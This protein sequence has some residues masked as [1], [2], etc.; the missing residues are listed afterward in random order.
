MYLWLSGRRGNVMF[1]EIHTRFLLLADGRLQQQS[2]AIARRVK[3]VQRGWHRDHG[4]DPRVAGT[5][6]SNLIGVPAITPVDGGVHGLVVV[7]QVLLN[8]GLRRLSTADTPQQP[9]I[10]VALVHP[11]GLPAWYECWIRIAGLLVPSVPRVR[12]RLTICKSIAAIQRQWTVRFGARF[13]TYGTVDDYVCVDSRHTPETAKTPEIAKPAE[14]PKP[15]KRLVLIRAYGA[16]SRIVRQ[17]DVGAHH[18]AL[19]IIAHTWD[20]WAMNPQ[21]AEARAFGVERLWNVVS[22]VAATITRLLAVVAKEAQPPNGLLRSEEHLL[23]AAIQRSRISTLP[24][25]LTKVLRPHLERQEEDESKPDAVGTVYA[26]IVR[27]LDKDALTRF[28]GPHAP[29]LTHVLVQRVGEQIRYIAAPE[30]LPRP[31]KLEN[32][33]WFVDTRLEQL[34][35]AMLAERYRESAD[36]LRT[37]VKPA[38]RG[39]FSG[40]LVE[41]DEAGVRKRAV[42]DSRSGP[43]PST[44]TIS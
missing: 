6:E 18:A 4:F 19:D 21:D 34:I 8:N 38:L 9:W 28:E 16:K 23:C 39:A 14:A 26:L 2:F 36:L 10:A 41:S 33:D 29:K 40:P 27:V 37:L 15:P 5:T 20:A 32:V 24:A 7:D 35:A 44:T 31:D 25:H 42:V 30:P 22:G 17:E 13:Y 1:C 43:P 12:D 11:R 3:A